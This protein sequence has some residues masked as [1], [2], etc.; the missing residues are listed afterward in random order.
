MNI[1]LNNAYHLAAVVLTSGLAGMVAHSVKKWTRKE[2]DSPLA[3]LL[4][5]NLRATV[6]SLGALLAAVLGA[7]TS[8]VF[9]GMTLVQ[10]VL[11]AFPYGYA[12]DS[13]VNKGAP[14]AP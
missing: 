2:T 5:D 1:D 9:S 14:S 4:R 6:A 10:V 12:N 8:D 13:V 7:V 11:T 3:Y